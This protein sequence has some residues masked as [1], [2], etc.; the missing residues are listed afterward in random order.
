MPFSA[1]AAI[2]R[3]QALKASGMEEPAEHPSL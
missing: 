2:E 1:R 3:Y